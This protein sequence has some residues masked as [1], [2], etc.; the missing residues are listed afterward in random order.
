MRVMQATFSNTGIRKMVIEASGRLWYLA[1]HN[2]H[3]GV[4]K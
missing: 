4:V 1:R 3:L 2:G